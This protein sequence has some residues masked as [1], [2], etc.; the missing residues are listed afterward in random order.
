MKTPTVLIV[1]DS[2]SCRALLQDLLAEN[3]FQPVL[4]S[5][6]AEATRLAR[7]SRPDVIIVDVVLPDVSGIELCGRWSQDPVLCDVPVL[8]VSGEQTDG[9]QRAAGFRC[10][11]RGYLVKPFSDTELIAQVRLLQQ[12]RRTH[13]ELVRRNRELEASNREL[14]QFAYVVSHDLK[15]P[16]RT[17]ASYCQLLQ[18]R[19]RGQLDAD[20]RQCIDFAVDG[21]RRMRQLID[22]LLTYSRVGRMEPASEPVDLDDLL[23]RVIA[24]LRRVVDEKSAAIHIGPL[25]VVSGSPYMLTQLFQ[26]LVENALRFTEKARPEIR[27]S[28]QEHG[29]CCRIAVADNGIGIRPDDA[30]R[31]FGVFS[32]LHTRDDYPGTGI[33]LAV[34][35]KIAQRHGGRIWVESELGRG[36]TFFV[37]L[38]KC[39]ET[40][41]QQNRSRGAHTALRHDQGSETL[42]TAAGP[43]E[44]PQDT[45]ADRALR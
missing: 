15:E 29:D 26:N 41:I 16:L 25:P 32:R 2:A 31:I 33:G 23:R 17:V 38:Q 1:D 7:R 9:E 40:Q 45:E 42:R 43:H 4:A 35:R 22:A 27:I 44:T 24:G 6:G 12:V 10:G 19:T 3:G 34:C 30:E 13:D 21:A 14:Q 11:A 20:S 8:L 36:S 5:D 39:P 18:R 28:S 37:V